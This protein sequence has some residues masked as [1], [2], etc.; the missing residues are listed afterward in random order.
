MHHVFRLSML[1]CMHVCTDGVYVSLHAR[2]RAD[3]F[4]LSVQLYQS[5]IYP[6]TSDRLRIPNAGQ[7]TW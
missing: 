6:Y 5:S 2:A 1:A 3:M 7:H 4:D